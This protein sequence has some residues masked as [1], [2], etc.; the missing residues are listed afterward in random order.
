MRDLAWAC[1]SPPLLHIDQVAGEAA[2]ISTAA[3]QLTRQRKSWL[4]RLDHDASAL[5]EHLATRPPR[6]LGEYF[7]QLWHFFLQQDPDTVLVA[8]NLAVREQGRTLG[9]F[10]CIYH[11]AERGGHVHLEL[12]VKFFLGTDSNGDGG[13]HSCQ[14]L[15][16]D[17]RDRLDIKLEQLLQRQI[18]LGDNPA[19]KQI[20]AELGVSGMS[21]E[22]VLKGYLFQ[23]HNAT[24][25]LPPGY[26]V[27][28]PLSRWVTTDQL[29]S[30][31]AELD[32]QSFL[33]LPRMRWLSAA[34]S[35]SPR[36]ATGLAELQNNLTHHF[37]QYDQPLLIAA[38]DGNGVEESRFI[39]TPRGWPGNSSQC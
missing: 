16:L 10:D 37:R 29:A 28:C 14:W 39:V 24:S 33:A 13:P 9:E 32:A 3:P 5:L 6:R 2:G 7:E 30:H 22:I 27:E 26:N 36:E 15:G 17:R 25:P 23:A 35:A 12:A 18:V 34:H 11:S 21:K 1:F 4:A 19:A 8:H 20:L 38:L 31:C